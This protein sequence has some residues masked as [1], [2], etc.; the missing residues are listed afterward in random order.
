MLDP[1]PFFIIPANRRQMK[2]RAIQLVV[3]L[4]LLA[5]PS[6]IFANPLKGTEWKANTMKK[7]G[8][9]IP[10]PPNASIT[11]LFS[12]TTLT[13]TYRFFTIQPP[14]PSINDEKF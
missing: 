12:E 1:H 6:L 14:N 7:D 10:L 8:K 3:L 9:I 5:V 2:T 4:A 11:F 13:S